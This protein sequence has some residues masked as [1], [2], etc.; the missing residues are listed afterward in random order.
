M[1]D[2]ISVQRGAHQ[3]FVVIADRHRGAVHDQDA[4]RPKSRTDPVGDYDQGARPLG[5]RML[6]PGLR[7]GIQV[8]GGLIQTGNPATGK[9]TSS[10]RA[11]IGLS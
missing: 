1:A 3:Q 8:T 2:Q 10:Q 7:G 4:S 11:T 6:D 5:E 9:S